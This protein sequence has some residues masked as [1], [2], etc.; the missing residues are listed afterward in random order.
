[1]RTIEPEINEGDSLPVTVS[2]ADVDWVSGAPSTVT[3]RIE[4]LTTGRTILDWTSV[5]P[6]SSV[7]ITASSANN[8]ILNDD[9][10]REIKQ[11]MVKAIDSGGNQRIDTYKYVVRNLQGIT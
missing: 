11:L 10:E 2:F 1:M 3:Y 4:C 9:N 6:A 8:A 7:T 5:T